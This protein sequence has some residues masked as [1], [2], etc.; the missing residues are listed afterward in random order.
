MFTLGSLLKYS[1]HVLQ[2]GKLETAQL[3]NNWYIDERKTEE[4]T[5]PKEH[6]TVISKGTTN[7]CNSKDASQLC[8]GEMSDTESNVLYHFMSMDFWKSTTRGRELY[9]SLPGYRS[10][11]RSLNVNSPREHFQ[12][13][14]TIS[15]FSLS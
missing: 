8:Q 5:R 11:G 1:I 14:G 3:F 2:I 7:A 4:Y 6:Y 12:T 15:T 9:L 10:A 13:T